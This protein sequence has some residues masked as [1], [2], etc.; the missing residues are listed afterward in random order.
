VS[1]TAI[2]FRRFRN[3]LRFKMN[4]SASRRV[5]SSVIPLALFLIA[6]PLLDAKH[7]VAQDLDNVTIS[8][9]VSDQNGGMIPGALIEANRRDT[10][11]RD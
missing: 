7:V 11:R 10:H 5:L 8:G 1:R 2:P 6:L 9:R 3:P 4:K